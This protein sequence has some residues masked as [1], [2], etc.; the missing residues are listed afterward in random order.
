MEGPL[1]KI[2][3]IP[4][5]VLLVVGMVLSAFLFYSLMKAA[6]NGNVLMVVILAIAISIVAFVV[7]R[8]IKFQNLKK[9]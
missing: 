7:S 9:F 6:E 4:P 2:Y 8:A 5:A 3:S 1:G